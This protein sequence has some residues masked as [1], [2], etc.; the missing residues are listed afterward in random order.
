VYKEYHVSNPMVFYNNE[1]LWDIANEKYMSEV[2]EVEAT[3]VM[4]KLPDEEEV[5]FLLTVPYT[6]RTKPNLTSLF[7]A[8]NDGDSYG[9]LFI[10]KFPKGETIDGPMMIESR[11]DQNTSISEEMTLWSQQG[12]RVLR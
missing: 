2:L 11:I 4:F 10:Y 12:S 9:K 1:D 8:R 3:Y 7:V 5:E 6:S